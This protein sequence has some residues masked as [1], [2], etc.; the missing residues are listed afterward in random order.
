MKF[1]IEM[2]QGTDAWER[3]RGKYTSRKDAQKAI[4]DKEAANRQG[5]EKREYRVV[6]AGEHGS[7]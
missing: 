3:I 7:V 2:R 4:K 5:S 6:E 1:V